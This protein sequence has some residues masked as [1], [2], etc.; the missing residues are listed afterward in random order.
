MIPVPA[1][2]WATVERPNPFVKVPGTV[3]GTTAVRQLIASGININI[4]LLFSLDAYRRVIDA[5][6]AGLEDRVG[7]GKQIAALHSVASFFVSR[8]DTE[9]DKRLEEL[10][11]RVPEQA[12]AARALL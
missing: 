1:T 9:T 10:A 8:V 11:T 2:R 3:E 12:E 4:T 5:Y 7:A 6:M